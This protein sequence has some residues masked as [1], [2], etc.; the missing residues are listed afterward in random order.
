MSYWWKPQFC[1][2]SYWW[3]PQFCLR[4]YWWKPQFCLPSYWWKPPTSNFSHQPTDMPTIWPADL[5]TYRVPH[6]F[7]LVLQEQIRGCPHI[8]SANSGGFEIA[9]FDTLDFLLNE[10]FIE[11]NTANFNILNNFFNW[12]LSKILKMS[13]FLNWILS[14]NLKINEF[15]NWTLSKKITIE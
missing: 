5:L 12:I 14:R 4:S 3:K 13:R 1:P 11:L 15:F 9:L 2:P 10:Y 8:L 7:W 6:D